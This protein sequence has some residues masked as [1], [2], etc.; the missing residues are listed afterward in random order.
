M[1]RKVLYVED[2]IDAV[3]FFKQIVRKIGDIELSVMENGT[4][5]LRF[6]N[7]ANAV[8]QD[9]PEIILLDI[10]LPGMSGIE[11]LKYL[12]SLSSFK[13]IPV[14]MFT[15]STYKEDIQKSYEYGANA[16][17]VKPSSLDALQTVLQDTFDFWLKHN[18]A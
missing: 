10:N 13:N 12:R 4:D 8:Q 7:D 14:I 5:L 9:L 11:I 18:V 3:V 1:S 15:S 17:L 6:T 16:Y 2:N